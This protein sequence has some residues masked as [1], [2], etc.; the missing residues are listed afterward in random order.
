MLEAGY[1]M[2]NSRMWMFGFSHL[3]TRSVSMGYNMEQS[4]IPINQARVLRTKNTILMRHDVSQ[5]L[6]TRISLTRINRHCEQTTKF[7]GVEHEVG[8]KVSQRPQAKED[9]SNSIANFLRPSKREGVIF[10]SK[11]ECKLAFKHV[12]ELG[13]RVEAQFSSYTTSKLQQNQSQKTEVSFKWYLKFMPF[14]NVKFYAG[15]RLSNT[16]QFIVG[17]KVAGIKL[18]MPWANLFRYFFPVYEWEYENEEDAPKPEPPQSPEQEQIWN[19]AKQTAMSLIF[20]GGNYLYQRH[21]VK[22]R[23]QEIENWINTEAFKLYNRQQAQI[24]LIQVKAE[25]MQMAMQEKLEIL[26]AFYGSK[27][28]ILEYV[29]GMRVD[30][31]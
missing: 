26:A 5:E 2:A 11:R 25:Q 24:K 30:A 27:L 22:Q 16:W 10:I 20:V 4:L 31:S 7:N 12:K 14:E 28:A 29:E 13:K 3:L 1:S 23:K 18:L 9:E 19:L 6:A 17:V 8:F 21:L 15:I